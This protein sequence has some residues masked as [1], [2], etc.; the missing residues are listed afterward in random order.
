MN[1]ILSL[2]LLASLAYTDAR[3]QQGPRRGDLPSQNHR[4][5]KTIDTNRDG[6]ISAEEL[7]AASKALTTLDTN[8]DG[9]LD[10]SEWR[11]NQIRGR[12]SRDRGPRSPRRGPTP[13]SR[14]N[15]HNDS[16]GGFVPDIFMKRVFSHDKNGDHL[17]SQDELPQ[18]L[19]RLLDNNDV[20]QDGL[21]S[22]AELKA[23]L[24]R[25]NQRFNRI[26]KRGASGKGRKDG[27]G[28]KR[29]PPRPPKG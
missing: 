10:P 18:S 26:P 23:S 19:I 25:L 14:P 16:I 29:P 6:L 3:A 12:K 21:L 20:N 17:L 11:E 5:L 13:P 1:P 22:K 7:Q 9:Q 15:D 27:K 8:G 4:I 28:R 2:L 24:D